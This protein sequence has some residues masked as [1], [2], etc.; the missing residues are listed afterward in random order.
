MYTTREYK[1]EIKGMRQDVHVQV[2]ATRWKT[3]QTD[4]YLILAELPFFLLPGESPFSDRRDTDNPWKPMQDVLAYKKRAL[5]NDRQ[6]EQ[7]FF[8]RRWTYDPRK[9]RATILIAR[10]HQDNFQPFPI[11]R[12]FDQWAERWYNLSRANGSVGALE[13]PLGDPA[14]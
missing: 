14:D 2:A 13:P 8:S 4:R 7:V 9:M 11:G 1:E 6:V 5:Y 3:H 10:M 12:F